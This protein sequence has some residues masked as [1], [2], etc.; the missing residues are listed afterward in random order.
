MCCCCGG[1]GPFGLAL[2][3]GWCSLEE[4]RS[5]M[6]PSYRTRPSRWVLANGHAST[7]SVGPYLELSGS[8]QP[9]HA[10][11]EHRSRLGHVLGTAGK[12]YTWKP[13]GAGGTRTHDLRFRKPSLYPAELQPHISKPIASE[14]PLQQPAST[15]RHLPAVGCLTSTLE[16]SRGDRDRWSVARVS[17]S[18]VLRPVEESPGSPMARPA[19]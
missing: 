14:A 10:K 17:A 1:S 16:S 18:V 8:V 4:S 6:W 19:G 5:P 13:N 7:S 3:A 11:F 2:Q 15:G 9:G 12:A